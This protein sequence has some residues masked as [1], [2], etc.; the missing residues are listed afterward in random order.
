MSTGLAS[1]LRPLGVFTPSC[2][3]VRFEG[4]ACPRARFQNRLHWV[5]PSCHRRIACTG[6]LV[7]VVEVHTGLF[8]WDDPVDNDDPSG[9]LVVIYTKLGHELNVYTGKIG[10]KVI[11]LDTC[12]GFIN[13]ISA[14]P[15]YSIT[16][17]DFIGHGNPNV[18]GVSNDNTPKE[19]IWQFSDGKVY[20]DG[21]S[22]NQTPKL[23]ADVLSKK[24]V[25]GSTINLEGC[26]VA[27]KNVFYPNL[28]NI[29]QAVSTILPDVY[30]TG[31]TFTTYGDQT[32]EGHS[33]RPFT[34]RT[35]YSSSTISIAVQ[36]SF[37]IDV[38]TPTV[39]S[40]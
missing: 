25:R 38:N 34:M 24:M 21:A 7:V 13:Q 18:Q 40:Y 5:R 9:L 26:S 12:R 36:P 39:F 28:P 32:P 37:E 20:L 14:L 6:V 23:L 1:S 15:D 8:G 22:I 17:I 11:Y 3:S 33:H 30:V 4:A 19:A 35:Y 2:R 10:G 29:C 31:S 27:A 16:D